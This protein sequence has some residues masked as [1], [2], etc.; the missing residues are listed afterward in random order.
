MVF[1][2]VVMVIVI[3]VVMVIVV[4]LERDEEVCAS[5]ERCLG[6]PVALGSLVVSSV[7]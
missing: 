3:V 7:E 1:G 5:V 4:L 2:V 6:D